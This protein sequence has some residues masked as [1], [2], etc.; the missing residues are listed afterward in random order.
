MVLEKP[1]SS[2]AKGILAV[3]T[4]FGTPPGRWIQ[5]KKLDLGP[6]SALSYVLLLATLI[7]SLAQFS[8]FGRKEKDFG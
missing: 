5:V 1:H 2:S 6:A 8:F 7:L 3:T 4:R